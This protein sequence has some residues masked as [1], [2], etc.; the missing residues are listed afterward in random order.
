MPIAL[1]SIALSGNY[2][3]TEVADLNIL[4]DATKR[5]NRQMLARACNAASK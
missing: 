3:L 1:V 2:R 4:Q 5:S